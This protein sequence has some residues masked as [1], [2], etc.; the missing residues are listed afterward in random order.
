MGIS[1]GE[2]YC[3]IFLPLTEFKTL[4]EKSKLNN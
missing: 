1:Q 4:T 2:T 3:F